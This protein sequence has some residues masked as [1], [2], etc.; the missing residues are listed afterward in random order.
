VAR[1][2]HIHDGRY[3]VES[4]SRVTEEEFLERIARLRPE[5]GE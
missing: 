2:M 1:T 3:D 5:S 4:S